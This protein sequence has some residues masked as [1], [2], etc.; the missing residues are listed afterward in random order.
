[1]LLNKLNHG[2][3]KAKER[4]Q[5][6]SNMLKEKNHGLGTDPEEKQQKQNKTKHQCFYLQLISFENKYQDNI[7]SLMPDNHEEYK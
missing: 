3:Q 1:M 6:R 4:E 2:K 7:L 5:R